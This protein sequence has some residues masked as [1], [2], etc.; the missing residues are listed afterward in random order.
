MQRIQNDLNN[1][2]SQVDQSR[3]SLSDLQKE[4]AT[5]VEESKKINSTQ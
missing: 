5:K 2:K 3:K 1:Q 4:Y